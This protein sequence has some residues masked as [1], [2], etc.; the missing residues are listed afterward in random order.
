MN[1]E[2]LPFESDNGDKEVDEAFLELLKGLNGEAPKDKAAIRQLAD[3]GLREQDV[4]KVCFSI[5]FVDAP[6]WLAQDAR[7]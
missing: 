7:W 2:T 6:Y 4:A 1:A 3:L 5:Q